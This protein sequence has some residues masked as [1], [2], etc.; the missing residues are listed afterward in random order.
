MQKIPRYDA[1]GHRDALT[2]L[3][4]QRA[5]IMHV[6]DLKR[7]VFP[8]SHRNADR[9]PH[10]SAAVNFKSIEKCTSRRLTF[11]RRALPSETVSNLGGANLPGG[12]GAAKSGASSRKDIVMLN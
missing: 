11:P 6:V 12:G 10:H 8:A 3:A 7:G 2:R 1:L 9:P 4:L 5:N